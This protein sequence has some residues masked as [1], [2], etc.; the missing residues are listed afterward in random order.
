M[1][2]NLPNVK[3]VSSFAAAAFCV[4]TLAG[5]SS[6]PG[7]PLLGAKSAPPIPEATTG[8]AV[9][10]DGYPNPLVDPV[11]VEGTPLTAAEQAQLQ[12]DLEAER[13]SAQSRAS[14]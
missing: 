5:C 4:A 2:I 7:A 6:Q 1:V 9:R 10:P 13:A 11:K 14:F 3:I 12:A 8:K